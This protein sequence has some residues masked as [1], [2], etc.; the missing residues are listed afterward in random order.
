MPRLMYCIS[1][2]LVIDLISGGHKLRPMCTFIKV[3]LFTLRYLIGNGKYYLSDSL[4]NAGYFVFN[5]SVQE[6]K[7]MYKNYTLF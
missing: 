1:V 2:Y 5:S 4:S 7:M 6:M 3:I